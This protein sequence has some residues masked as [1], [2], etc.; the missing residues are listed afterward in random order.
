F[1]AMLAHELRNPLAAACNAIKLARTSD[2]QNEVDWSFNV[3]NRQMRHLARLIDDLLDVSRISRG[4]IELRRE[5]VDAT[6][7][8]ENAVETARPLFEERRHR[9]DLA[10]DRGNIWVDVDA[11]RLEQIVVNLLNNAAK[12]STKEGRIALAAGR[13]RGEVMISV[14][15]DGIG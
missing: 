7:I 12:Y 10:I 14:R 3:I 8:I 15:D 2:Q 11:T 13:E 9:L 1:L 4:K 5:K 6:S